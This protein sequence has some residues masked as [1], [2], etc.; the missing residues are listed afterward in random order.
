MLSRELDSAGIIVFDTSLQ[1]ATGLVS[2]AL[3]RIPHVVDEACGSGGPSC[4]AFMAETA[5]LVVARAD[6]VFS[7][8]TE[9]RGG[10]AG[11]EGQKQCIGAV[12]RY[13]L[14]A[15]VD[16]DRHGHGHAGAPARSSITV[17]DLRSKFISF[18]YQLPLGDRVLHC[19]QDHSE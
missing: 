15:S 18:Y 2:P 14:V 12:G 3:R 4:A 5:E 8:S 1:G 13:V 9:D 6:G 10:A 7:Y 16:V 11:I 17:Y 19:L